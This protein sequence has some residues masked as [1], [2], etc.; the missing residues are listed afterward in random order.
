MN[1]RQRK[2]QAKR[3]KPWYF[4][5]EQKRWIGQETARHLMYNYLL[6][7]LYGRKRT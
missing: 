3:G 1:K 6:K 4:T 2:K 7:V 5:R